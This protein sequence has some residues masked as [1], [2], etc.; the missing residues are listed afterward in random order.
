MDDCEKLLPPWLRFVKGVVDAADLPLN[1]SREMIQE[2]RML[3]KI[4]KNLTNKILATLE[5]FKKEDGEKYRG[6]FKAFGGVIKEGAALD[7]EHR[8][9]LADLLLVETT[10]TEAGK[11]ATLREVRDR[12][13]EGQDAI[14]YLTGERRDLLEKSPLLEAFKERNWEVLFFTE[15][16]DEWLLQSLDKYDDKPLK[17]ADKGDLPAEKTAERE[18]QQETFKDY[19]E[20]LKGKLGEAVKE[21]RLSARLKESAACLVS[22]EHAMGA[23]MERLMKRMGRES[24]M[25]AEA[26]I[27][28]LNPEHATVRAL[29]A[30]YEKDQDDPRL[31]SYGR[32]LYEEAVLA[33]G[34]PLA[35]PKAFLERVNALMARDLGAS[36]SH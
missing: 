25:P 2:N 18:K 24:E 7:F 32:L 21:V 31:E 26:R 4:R 34:T 11:P 17:A 23:H 22:D 6:F 3:D 5:E 15:P 33:E 1:V 30:L 12:M 14:Y 10:A 28:E 20:F 27:L 29:H 13:P 36:E 16:I 8:E 35:D 9:K 19:L